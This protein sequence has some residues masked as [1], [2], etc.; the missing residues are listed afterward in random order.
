MIAATVVPT[1][2]KIRSHPAITRQRKGHVVRQKLGAPTKPDVVKSAKP[3]PK[4]RKPISLKKLNANIKAA[5]DS[6]DLNRMHARVHGAYANLCMIVG[7]ELKKPP[8]KRGWREI[9]RYHTE[10]AATVREMVEALELDKD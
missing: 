3:E 9:Q 7:I 5:K 2:G 4:P 1:V 8:S 10:A 6:G